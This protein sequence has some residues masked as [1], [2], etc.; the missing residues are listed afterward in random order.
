MS[1]SLYPILHIL[2]KLYLLKALA[3]FEGSG[4]LSY[5]YRHLKLLIRKDQRKSEIDI[6]FSFYF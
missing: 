2:F 6:P 3:V 5:T 1:I 4:L